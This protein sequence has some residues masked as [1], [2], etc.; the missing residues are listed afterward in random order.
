M[1]SCIFLDI[2]IKLTLLTMICEVEEILCELTG[3]WAIALITVGIF[4]AVLSMSILLDE[5]WFIT[6]VD[7]NTAAS[8]FWS[9]GSKPQKSVIKR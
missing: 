8:I 9:A 4:F 7:Q 2:L 1:Q 6:M 5:L 3:P